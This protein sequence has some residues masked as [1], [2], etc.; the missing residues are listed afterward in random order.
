M[1]PYSADLRQRIVAA[2]A[3]GEHSLRQIA[4]VFSV[5][6]SFLVRLQ[7]RQ[8]R[9]G[10]IHPKPH[11][12]GPTP[13][14]DDQACQ[15]LLQLVHQQ[16]DATLAELRDR[17]GI[18]CGIMTIARALR[19]HGIRRKKKTRHAQERDNPEVQEQRAAFDRKMAGVERGR[20]LFVDE[21]GTTT[22]MTRTYGRARGG[23][24]LEASVPQQWTTLTLI[25]GLRSTEVLAPFAFEGATDTA[26]FQ[27]YVE[28]VLVPQVR[29]GDVV[30]W[31]NLQAHKNAEVV[32]AIEAA[33]GRV[34]RLPPYS[35]DKSPIEEMFSK[36]KASLRTAAARTTERV[37]DALGEALKQ[38]TPSDIYGWF[39]DRCA[40][41]MH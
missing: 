20:L 25:A 10:T 6:L 16:P 4:H 11:A 15:R 3:R 1:R 37:V 33:G 2:I 36:V 9:D 23:E 18:S 28:K 39:Q 22:N 14:L 21:T 5:S 12:G 31:D 19:R 26:A 29:V 24:R 27:T 8:R 13:R 41:A 17:L 35:P 34:E 7:Q 38:I 40:Y 32:A 30:V